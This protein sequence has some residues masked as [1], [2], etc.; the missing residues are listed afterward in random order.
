MV[1]ALEVPA[2]MLIR[3]VAAKLKEKYPQVK[4]PVW[5]YFAEGWRERA[6]TYTP[7]A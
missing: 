7:A 6:E 1:T 5:A 3:R 4:P 2:D